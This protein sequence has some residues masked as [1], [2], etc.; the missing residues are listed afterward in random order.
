MSGIHFPAGL[1]ALMQELGELKRLRSAARTGSLAQR[2]FAESW[3]GLAGGGDPRDVMTTTIRRT[4]C[5][6]RLGDIDARTLHELGLD[7]AAVGA[8]LRRGF[9]DVAEA[10]DP[11]LRMTLE[12]AEAAV[13]PVAALPDF[14]I[15]LGEQPRAGVTCPG[16]PRLVLEPAENHAEH[17]QMVA[18]YGVLISPMFGADAQ[19]VWL[20]GLSHHLHNAFLPDSGFAG[21]MLLGAA[22]GPLVERANTRALSQLTEPLARSVVHARQILADA[23]TPE[24]RAFHAADTLDRVWQIAQH[25]RV[26]GISLDAVLGEM[27]LVHEGPV[28]PFQ[29][30]VLRAAGLLA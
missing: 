21:E 4:L 27:A 14:V 30:D 20:A 12:I 7:D 8:V 2:L 1:L 10:L 25:L 26:C 22:L 13:A 18:A 9:A 15:R 24:G 17:C 11:S 19:T 23:R 3:S 6:T 16:R 28:K 29:D 5:A